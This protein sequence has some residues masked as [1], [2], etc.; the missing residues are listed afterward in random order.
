VVDD[1]TAAVVVVSVHRRSLCASVVGVVDV[2]A[3]AVALVVLGA[4]AVT[5]DE[6]LVAVVSTD[7]ASAVDP[8]TS[9][10][11]TVADRFATDTGSLLAVSASPPQLAASSIT[12]VTAA[13]RPRS[14]ASSPIATPSTHPNPTPQGTTPD[15]DELAALARLVRVASDQRPWAITPS[16][17]RRRT[18][19]GAREAIGAVRRCDV[20]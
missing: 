11:A 3:G 20:R 8:G 1:V 4:E 19:D 10:D 2:L 14:R 16:S 5:T 18:G 7:W 9:V 6:L 17:I 12:S 13:E 15:A